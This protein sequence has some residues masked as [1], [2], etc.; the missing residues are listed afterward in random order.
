MSKTLDS[1]QANYTVTEMRM[2]APVF[3][4]DKF[5]SYL[6]GTKVIVYTNHAAIMYLF[7]KKDAKSRLIW[8]ILL[9]QE[10]APQIRDRKSTQNQIVDHLS[11]LEDSS[12]VHN[13]GQIHEEFL[14]EQ[15]LAL[16]VN[17]LSWYADIVN[18]LVSKVFPPFRRHQQLMI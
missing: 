18:L 17:Q 16:D 4:F 13:G 10:F 1:T 3:A 11:R 14:D 2:L 6:V 5:R 7:N 8:W 9:L 15:L 12:H